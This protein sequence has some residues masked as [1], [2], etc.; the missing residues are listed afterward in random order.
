M[1]EETNPKLYEPLPA[2]S[3]AGTAG[4]RGLRPERDARRSP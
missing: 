2:Y 1:D 4:G 3:Q